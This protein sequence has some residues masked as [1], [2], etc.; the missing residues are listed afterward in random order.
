MSVINREAH[1]ES[2]YRTKK[3]TEVSWYQPLPETSLNFVHDLSIK[4]DSKIIDIGGGDSLFVD[5]LLDLGF[6]NITV[7]DISK[8]AIERAKKR[9]GKKAQLVK[10]IVSDITD[11][12]PIEKYDFWHDRAAFHFLTKSN[13]IEK[14][15]NIVNQSI[16]DNGFMVIGTFSEKGPKKC[17]GIEI[18]Q[19]SEKSMTHQF[20]ASFDVQKCI[21]VNHTTPSGN[22]QHFVFCCFK[23]K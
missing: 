9:L 19:Y 1:W 14:Y 18:K 15:H 10:W 3:L 17:S 4:K 6:V 5:H 20:L 7:L 2:I 8:T 12:K 23:K 13:E 22:H 11:F 16:A 21:E